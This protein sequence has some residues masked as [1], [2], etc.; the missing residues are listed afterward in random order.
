VSAAFA[1]SLRA[2]P[3][4]SLLS[5]P[6]L[7]SLSLRPGNSLAAPKAA[8]SMGFSS[9]GFPPGCHPSYGVSAY[10]PCGSISHRAC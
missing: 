9:L 3:P 2:R 4:D 8:L 10:F 5:R 6:L 7:R 1:L